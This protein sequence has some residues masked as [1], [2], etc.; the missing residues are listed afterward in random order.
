MWISLRLHKNLT[1]L[2]HCPH[3]LCFRVRTIAHQVRRDLLESRQQ[4]F[5]VVSAHCWDS[6]MP[7][8]DST[9]CPSADRRWRA[10]FVRSRSDGEPECAWIN[11]ENKHNKKN[12]FLTSWFSLTAMVLSL[13]SLVFAASNCCDR[14]A[15]SLSS[16]MLNGR[17]DMAGDRSENECWC[18]I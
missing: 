7:W 1:W 8:A 12:L 9:F 15:F 5:V 3:L 11:Y 4:Q 16:K 10:V 18:E 13:H 14:P 6:S 17:L 2:S